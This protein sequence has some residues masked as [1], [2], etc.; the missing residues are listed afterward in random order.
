VIQL[1]SLLSEQIA[2][3]A[4]GRPDAG[5]IFS[6]RPDLLGMKVDML[7]IGKL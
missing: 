3:E 7:G 6:D 4:N 1:A 2:L 5:T